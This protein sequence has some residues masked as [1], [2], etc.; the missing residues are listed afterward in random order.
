MMKGPKKSVG[1]Q[2]PLEL[3]ERIKAQA[4]DRYRTV[5]GYIRQVMERYL[6]YVEHEPEALTGRWEI[7]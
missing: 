3:Y 2:M 7:R 4:E 1:V 5:P 6:W